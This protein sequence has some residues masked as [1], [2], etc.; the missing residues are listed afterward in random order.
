MPDFSFFS[1]GAF[2]LHD[3]IGNSAHH[4]CSLKKVPGGLRE[5][6]VPY[7]TAEDGRMSMNPAGLSRECP[8][9][10]INLLMFSSQACKQ[11]TQNIQLK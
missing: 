1:V 2:I 7:T 3:S 10:T 4:V 11:G 5:R 8:F 9:L 6:A